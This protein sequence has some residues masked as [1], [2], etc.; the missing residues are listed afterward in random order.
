[1]KL[2]RVDINLYDRTQS[3]VQPIIEVQSL[4]EAIRKTFF[5]E[6]Y[7]VEQ[8]EVDNILA[9]FVEKDNMFIADGDELSTI[10]FKV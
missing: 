10:F 2:L 5:K 6:G 4:D 7:D 9:E 1:M 3:D 8:Y